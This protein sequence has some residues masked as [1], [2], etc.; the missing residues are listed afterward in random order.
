[1][2]HFIIPS[3]ITIPKSEPND[4]PAP[5]YKRNPITIYTHIHI[6]QQYQN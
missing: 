4:T 3:P 5:F 2:A 1:V 6:V